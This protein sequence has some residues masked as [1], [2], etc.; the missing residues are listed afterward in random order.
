MRSKQKGSPKPSFTSGLL[1][2]LVT[3]LI[4]LFVIEKIAEI[5]FPAT[6]QWD[7]RL[8]FFSEGNVFQNMSWGGFV[9]QPNTKITARIVYIT[10]PKRPTVVDEYQYQISTNSAGLVQIG[11]IKSATPSVIFLG[12]S[13]TAG[14]GAIPW[15]YELERR[16]KGYSSFQIIN[17]G[18][19]GTGF[20]AWLRLYQHLATSAD[21]RKIVVIFISSDWT[22]AV[23]QM[24]N[25]DLNC[26]KQPTQCDGSNNFLGLPA[27]P[28]DAEH[29]IHRIATERMNYL[30]RNQNIFE[31]SAIYQRLLH[32]AYS[33]WWPYRK[34]AT[35]TQFEKS[36]DAIREM[37]RAVGNQNIVF[38]QLPQKDEL[39]SG[40]D[41]LSERGQSFIRQSGLKYVDGN[42]ECQLT[43]EDFHVHDGHP[44]SAGYR[45]ILDCVE[46]SVRNAFEPM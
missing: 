11:N 45:K 10:D 23:W 32:P 3:T 15:F 43:I 30:A 33:R 35:E 34:S 8:M 27:N 37:T 42:K 29:Q 25:H 41:S 2:S 4:I 6:Y 20:E 13:Y 12:D 38:I 40:L 44:N 5:Y 14:Q 17:G 9:Y 16:W 26:L 31:A 1:T 46:R 21:I 36:K 18:I 19:L 28:A 39:A 24:S 22:R 7:R